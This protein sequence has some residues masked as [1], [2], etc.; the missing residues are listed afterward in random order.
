[1]NILLVTNHFYP[2]EFRCND[3]AFELAHRGHRVSV[4]TAIPDYPK[5]KFHCGYG[6]FRKRVEWLNGVKVYRSFII[7]RGK[8]GAFR[9]MLNYG[10]SLL[11]QCWDAFLLGLF[12]RYDYVLVHETSPV[13]VGVPGIIVSKMKHIPMDFWVL[14]LWP[15]SLQDAG[16]VNSLKVL[17][18]FDKLT[19]WIY[20][21]AKHILISSRGFEGSICEKGDFA[22]KV[23][24][25]PNWADISLGEQSFDNKLPKMPEGFKVMFAGNIGEAQDMDSLMETALVLKDEKDIHFCIVGDGRKRPWVEDFVREHDLTST[26]HMLGRFPIEMMPA[27]FTIADVLLVTLKDSKV[28]NRT[29]P[30]KIQAYMNAGK[31][32]AAMLNGEGSVVISNAECGFC[33]AAGDAGAFAHLLKHMKAM[34]HDKLVEMGIRG[35]QYC[36]EYFDFSKALITIEKLMSNINK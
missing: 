22:N 15:E 16:G 27:F 36:K 17:G 31:P 7:P 34:E 10:S 9:L 5:G 24:Y 6:I 8:G 13:M 12:G 11:S 26:V 14:D 3:L 21:S 20:R 29:A 23:I 4:L 33:V 1:M 32:I 35:K 28:F 30:A 2:E 19:T 18:L 25:F